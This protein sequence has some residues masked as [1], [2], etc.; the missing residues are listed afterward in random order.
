MLNRH[1]KA[2]FFGSVPKVYFDYNMNRDVFVNIGR[3][4]TKF[5]LNLLGLF[6]FATSQ[7]IANFS[8]ITQ[9]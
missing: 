8:A 7:I 2:P 4:K 1:K 3:Y 5:L 9:L 6:F